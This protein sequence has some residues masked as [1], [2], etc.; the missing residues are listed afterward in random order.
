MY[1]S[2]SVLVFTHCL[3]LY[4]NTEGFNIW[5]NKHYNINNNLIP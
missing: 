5:Y 3:E 4:I 1:R 2:K